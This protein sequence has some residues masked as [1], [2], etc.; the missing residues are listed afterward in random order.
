M[1]DDAQY[2]NHSPTFR[3]LYA[4]KQYRE[5]YPLPLDIHK[6]IQK[7]FNFQFLKDVA[8][9]RLLDDST[10]SLIT[11]LINQN[12][13]DILEWFQFDAT[14]L[15]NVVKLATRTINPDETIKERTDEI[16]KALSFLLELSL[17]AKHQHV[18]NKYAFYKNLAHHGVYTLFFV[19]L[20]DSAMSTHAIKLASCQLL[21]TLLEHDPYFTILVFA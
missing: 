13:T 14:Y 12:Q 1:L 16:Q 6:K 4:T 3:H 9:A 8:L 10:F 19:N 15:T 20:A 17:V 7:T 18:Q 2:P 21:L 5:I 11:N